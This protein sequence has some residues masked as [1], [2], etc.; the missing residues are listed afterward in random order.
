MTVVSTVPLVHTVPL[1]SLVSVAVSVRTFG[2]S[3]ASGVIGVCSCI[4]EEL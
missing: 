2:D 1:V 3:S 4:C